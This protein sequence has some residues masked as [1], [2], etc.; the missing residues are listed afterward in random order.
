MRELQ[1]RLFG[2]ERVLKGT[3]FSTF[4]FKC[5][6]IICNFVEKDARLAFDVTGLCGGRM[7]AKAHTGQQAEEHSQ[8]NIN[9]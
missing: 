9:Y 1:K 7:T 8:V 6:T 4:L 3:F 5:K 2:I